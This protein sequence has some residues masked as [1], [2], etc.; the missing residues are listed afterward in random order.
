MYS[1]LCLLAWPLANQVSLSHICRASKAKFNEGLQHNTCRVYQGEQ[2]MFQS[3][4]AWYHL[5]A[6]PALE[7]TLMVFATYLDEHLQ[8]HYT[9]VH[10]YMAP[11]HVAHIALGLPNPLQNCPHLQQLLWEICQLQPQPQPDSGHQSITTEFLCRARPLHWLHLPKDSVLWAALTLGH[12]GLFHSGKL[13]QWKLAE[14]GLP[15]YICVRD[16][17]PHFSQGCLHYVCIMLSGS[18]TDPF[19]VGCSVIIG[20]TGTPVCEAC[21]AW[22]IIQQHQW[23]QTSP[24][25]PFLQIDGRTLDH[26]TLVRHIKDIVAKLGLNPFRYS[27]HSLC[28]RG[29][30][31]A[32]QVGLSQWQIKLLGRRNSQAYQVYIQQDQLACVGLAAHMAANS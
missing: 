3:F 25:A 12:Y 14:A 28:I 20:C 1:P 6:F 30:T 32:V 19:H 5:T 4:C 17:T 2:Q 16:V 7:D 11:I 27:G 21:E 10:H 8:R 13:V 29:A 9:T 31:S 18:K 24:D 23:T 15:W 26:L 22:S